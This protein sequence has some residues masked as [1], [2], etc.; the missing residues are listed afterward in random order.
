MI[1]EIKELFDKRDK[2]EDYDMEDH[3][4]AKLDRE[5]VEGA[6]ILIYWVNEY[7]QFDQT[8]DKGYL[9]VLPGMDAQICDCFFHVPNPENPGGKGEAPEE[10]GYLVELIIN[11]LVEKISIL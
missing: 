11:P 10:F 8:I 9:F 1:P 7:K 5:C 3:H 4:F 6:K 2:Y